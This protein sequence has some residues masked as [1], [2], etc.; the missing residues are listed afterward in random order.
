MPSRSGGSPHGSTASSIFASPSWAHP[1]GTDQLGRD[2]LLELA[3]GAPASLIVGAGATA[4]SVAIGSTIGLMSGFLGG[5]V[6]AGLMRL[7]DIMLTIPTL[8]LIIVLAAIIGQGLTQVVL[9]IGFTGWA[10]LARLVRSE[11]LSLRERTFIL[12]AR[13]VGASRARIIGVHLLPLVVPLLVANTVLIAAAAILNA[14]TLSF[15]GLG[16]ITMP[17]WGLM[18]NNAFT[19]GAAG[20]GAWWFVIP[21]G[22][23]ILLL[24]LSLAALGHAINEEMSPQL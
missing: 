3:A 19:S 7:T 6:D 8:P 12:R 5:R 18:L 16:D 24:V 21:P 20:R 15:L 2:V 14:A 22:M 10:V 11:V 9:V 4:I 1:L 13:S 17:S 23:C